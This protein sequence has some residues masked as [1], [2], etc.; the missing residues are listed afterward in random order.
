MK[1]RPINK[2]WSE[3]SN[4]ALKKPDSSTSTS[5]TGENVY[6]KRQ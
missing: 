4:F 5:E 3:I 2:Y 6:I 1:I